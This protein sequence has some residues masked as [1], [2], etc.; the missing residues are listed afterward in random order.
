MFNLKHLYFQ[1]CLKKEIF[2]V[3]ECSVFI[4][5]KTKHLPVNYLLKKHLQVKE[6]GDTKIIMKLIIK[7]VTFNLK[8]L[9]LYLEQYAR[10]VNRGGMAHL[11]IWNFPGGPY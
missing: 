2:Q 6:K 5:S 9:I 11:K 1:H 3:N 10:V 4:Q 7:C 8:V